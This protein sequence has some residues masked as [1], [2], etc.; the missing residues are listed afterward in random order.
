M[1][2]S[3][4]IILVLGAAV[5]GT[6]LLLALLL[7]NEQTR[8]VL[9]ALVLVPVVF[10]IALVM[11]AGWQ[12]MAVVRHHARPAMPVAI[13]GHSKVDVAQSP[14]TAAREAERTEP[15]EIDLSPD[16]DRP[17]WVDSPGR[18]VDGVYR[19]AVSAGPYTTR[20]ECEREL[21]KQL[22]AAVDEYVELYLGPQA[23]HR[24][25]LPSDDIR[26]NLVKEEWLESRRVTVSPTR[27]VPMVRLHA[28]L[29]FD[30]EVNAH[31]DE[32][33]RRAVVRGKLWAMGTAGSVLL[34]VLSA[35]WGYLKTD[36]ATGGAYRW[37]LRVAT[38]LAV[39]MVL[40]IGLAALRLSG[41]H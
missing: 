15:S 23:V 36:L 10:M 31:L 4:F 11:L 9:K 20:A 33:W 30:R 38:G 29:E 12:R 35:C 28:L 13:V 25:E 40:L 24:V 16:P 6:V 39:A 18:Q 8:A 34:L 7:T 17:Q 32:A 26:Q 5:L 27:Q 1:A 19:A 3:V 2:I 21:P 37:R 41:V 14:V 22:R